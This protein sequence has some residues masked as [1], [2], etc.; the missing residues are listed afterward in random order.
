M[1]ASP[2]SN[3]VIDKTVTAREEAAKPGSSIIGFHCIGCNV[4]FSHFSMLRLRVILKE[5]W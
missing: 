1:K 4:R 2:T 3:F 5:D